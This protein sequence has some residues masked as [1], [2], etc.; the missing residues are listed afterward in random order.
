MYVETL[1]EAVDRVVS[2]IEPVGMT[3]HRP[4]TPLTPVQPPCVMVAVPTV[5]DQEPMPAGCGPRYQV[6]V[7]VLVIGENPA[8]KGLLARVDAVLAALSSAHVTIQSAR[9]Q[10][11]EATNSPA[12]IPGV[13]ITVE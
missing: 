5:L 2:A 10:P 4:P 1:V 12:P 13:Q 8:G 3:V 6:S 7:D 9:E 11:F